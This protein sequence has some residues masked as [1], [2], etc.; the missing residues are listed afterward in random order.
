MQPTYPHKFIADNGL[1]NIKKGS[2]SPLC[3][4]LP[5]LCELAFRRQFLEGTRNKK[6][7]KEEMVAGGSEVGERRQGRHKTNMHVSPGDFVC[8][9][10]HLPDCSSWY[11][12]LLNAFPCT[13]W[14]KNSEN[15]RNNTQIYE[16]N[17]ITSTH[18]FV[19]MQCTWREDG[20]L[21]GFACNV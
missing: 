6:T 1:A 20:E 5:V 11:Q 16:T 13:V 17:F 2:W 18:K 19:C 9:A 21:G 12:S 15:L 4:P 14:P 7:E 10:S 8:S 3:S